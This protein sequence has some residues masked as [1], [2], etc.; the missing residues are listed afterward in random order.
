[1]IW[2]EGADGARPLDEVPAAVDRLRRTLEPYGLA[3]SLALY[4][5]D[6]ADLPREA[7]DRCRALE[8]ATAA[9]LLLNLQYYLRADVV[10]RFRR[11]ALL[12]IDPGLLQL[13]ISGGH[14]PV[15]PHDLYFTIGETVGT[16]SA[17]FPDCGLDWHYTP[18]PVF[19]PAWTPVEADRAAAYTTVSNW[20]G[21]WIEIGGEMVGN[22]KRTAFLPYADLPA[23]TL[24]RLELAL[25]I[26]EDDPERSF[27]EERGWRVE[28]AWDVCATP[29]RYRD[30]IGRS[31]GEFSCAKPS[32]ARL[33]NAW[34]S[35]RTLCYLAS[36]KPAVVEHTGPS[37]V[38]PEAAGLHRFRTPG[39][40]IAALGAVEDD[41]EAECRRAR[42]LVEA[43]FDAVH[44]VGDVLER[45]LA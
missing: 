33:E 35:D 43:H 9:D 13:W 36:G 32:C 42:E 14:I 28:Y 30:Y 40:A 41:Y 16:S 27:L 7:S 12:D 5:W 6:G 24:A 31:R 21:G 22:E 25:C 3:D 17:A 26:S 34:V 23:R 18:P 45:A 19:L 37:R 38:L 39:E 44:V 11:A 2:L 10:A 15:A 8:E 1:M 4:S 29:E 20:W